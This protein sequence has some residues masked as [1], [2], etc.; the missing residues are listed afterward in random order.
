VIEGHTIFSVMLFSEAKI[1]VGCLASYNEGNL[2]GKWVSLSKFD[3]EEEFYE[4]VREHF[5]KLDESHPLM[6]GL[7][8]EEWMFNDWEGIP[9]HLI[10]EYSLDSK[11]WELKEQFD[12]VDE[13]REAALFIL[14]EQQDFKS[15]DKILEYF[16]NAYMGH[17]EGSDPL[18]E[19]AE[20]DAEQQFGQELLTRLG[21]Y[22]DYDQYK[23]DLDAQGYWEKD[24][25]VFCPY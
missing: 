21:S 13:Y 4:A 9:S 16:E 7:P 10:S 19:F 25:H 24:G 1:W 8:R 17:Y 22:F 18:K 5:K 23:Y 12:E 15:V 2:Y 6:S 11:F 3:S 14:L 20:D